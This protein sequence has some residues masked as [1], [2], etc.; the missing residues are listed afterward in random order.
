MTDPTVSVALATFNGKRFIEAQL[1]SILEQSQRPTEIVVS[2]GGSTDATLE[3]VRGVLNAAAVG[4]SVTVISD[5]TRLGVVENFERA[6]A[7][8][9]GELVM[10]SDQDDIWHPD[11]TAWAVTAF[12]DPALLLLHG[13]ARLIDADGAPL[14]EE[15]FDA[16]RIGQT[17]RETI[18]GEAAFALLIRRNLVT[19]A[20]ATFRRSLLADALPIPPAW[21][22]DEWLAAIAAATG[23]L[24]ADDRAVIDYRQHGANAIG[25]RRLSRA[26]RIAKT[27]EPRNGRLIALSAR[28]DALAVRLR[29]L[30]VAE[31]WQTLAHRKAEFE[32]VRADYPRSRFCR[33]LPVLRQWRAGRY[34]K[35]ASQGNADI[36]RD[37]VQSAGVEPRV[38]HGLAPAG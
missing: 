18:C 15:L 24:R 32:R 6:I 4:L 30:E 37:L 27:F 5:G 3:I 9:T 1:R 19:G 21:V 36:V 26:Q 7:A 35:L 31:R 8:T 14:G 12:E 10:L 2:D 16:L 23:R 11:R 33:L 20:T 22:H 29:I 38:G 13:N 25:V 28:A 17:E 34:A